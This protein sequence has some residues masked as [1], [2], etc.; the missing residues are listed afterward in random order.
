M[1]FNRRPSNGA[2]VTRHL[3]KHLGTPFSELEETVG[4]G[5]KVRLGGFADVPGDEQVTL[6]T[7]GLADAARR[8]GWARSD[9]YA[10]ELVFVFDRR[11][12][13]EE[14]LDFVLTC[15]RR[16]VEQRQLLSWTEPVRLNAPVP[17]STDMHFLLPTPAALFDDDFQFVAGPDGETDFCLLVPA[18]PAEAEF[19]AANGPDAFYDA[20]EEHE[21][22]VSDLGRAV[23]PAA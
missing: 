23:L 7:Q 2:E 17:S 21:V 1:R 16:F 8:G 15:A 18:Y 12:F 10:Q 13:G 20:L 9:G 5:V 22:D 19:L 14:I 4:G 3:R 6:V 11:C